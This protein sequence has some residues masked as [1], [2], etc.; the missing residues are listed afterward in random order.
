MSVVD[1]IKSLETKQ[2]IMLVAIV[3]L[4]GVAIY[5]GYTTFFPSTTS[6]TPVPVKS[7]V[8]PSAAKQTTQPPKKTSRST[9]QTAQQKQNDEQGQL[10]F[11]EKPKTSAPTPEQLAILAQSQQLQ[12]EYIHLVS[13]YQIAQ[14]E[15]KLAQTNAAIAQQK[16]SATKSFIETQKL[17]GALSQAPHVGM[18]SSNSHD[19]QTSTASGLMR[20]MYVGRQNGHWTAMLGSNGNYFEV[21]VGTHLPDGSVVSA[22]SNKGVTLKK[23]GKL[24]YLAIPRTLD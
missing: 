2:K 5:M 6:S 17:Q 1:N 24:T 16:L 4:L 9:R 18:T 20:A 21:K 15:Q 19:S 23:A 12:E 7:S 13:Q 8:P 14:L 10:Q 22:I 11:L 3:I